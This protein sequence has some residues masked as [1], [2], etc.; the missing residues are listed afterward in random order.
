M[1]DNQATNTDQAQKQAI[2]KPFKGSE[3]TIKNL[4]TLPDSEGDRESLL[5][6]VVDTPQESQPAQEE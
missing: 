4:S 1:T 6:Q 5:D 2:E 3:G